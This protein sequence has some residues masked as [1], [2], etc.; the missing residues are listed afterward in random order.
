[1]STPREEWLALDPATRREARQHA[2]RLRPHPSPEVSAAAARYARSYLNGRPWNP[3]RFP[4]MFAA[5]LLAAIA[6]GAGIGVAFAMLSG[7]GGGGMGTSF[8]LVAV[9]AGIAV[10]SP[11]TARRVRLVRMCRLE[12][13]NNQALEDAVAGA[14]AAAPAGWSP[15]ALAWPPPAA[16]RDLSV[17]YDA[18]RLRRRY[19]WTLVSVLAMALIVAGAALTGADPVT[20][21]IVGGAFAIALLPVIA[22][23]A[24]LL[25]RW[26]LPGRPVVGIDEA[27]LHVPLIG[28]DLPWSSIA[29]I[30]LYPMRFLRRDGRPSVVVAF[31]P[32]DPAAL[33]GAL[34]VSARRRRRLE[35][36]A[37]VYGTPLSVSDALITHS[38]EQLAAAASA[39]SGLPIRRY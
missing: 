33:A 25:V 4:L 38:G 20:T 3:R 23:L 21:G 27:G 31:V 12:L 29:E 32:R 14:A 6:A 16:D 26:V 36:S 30:R 1:M 15:P 39:H 7:P 24:V 8:W 9:A 11:L 13:A 18:R 22:A 28:C 34:P 5:M 2:R 19:A 17:R 10:T 37:R 35:K